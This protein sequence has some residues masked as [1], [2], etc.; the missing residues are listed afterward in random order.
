[1][2]PTIVKLDEKQIAGL[3]IRTTNQEESA[4]AG[5]IG[6]LWQR[7]YQGGY[8]ERTPNRKEPGAV[9]GVYSEYESDENGAYT[10]LVGVEIE[11]DSKVPDDMALVTLPEATYAVFTTRMGPAAE[12]VT[13]AWGQIWEWSRQPGNKRT[14]SGDFERYDAERCSDPNHVQVDLYIAIDPS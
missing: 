4:G 12:V 6:D 10:L 9:L 8:P 11:S 2:N 13:E 5:K 1:M 7:Y 14:F 3:Q